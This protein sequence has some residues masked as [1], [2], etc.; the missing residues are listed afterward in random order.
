M[1]RPQIH[2]LTF[3]SLTHSTGYLVGWESNGWD[4]CTWHRTLKGAIR[5][6]LKRDG[7]EVHRILSDDHTERVHV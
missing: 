7:S 2:N 6:H 4:Y 5:E 1:S 3:D